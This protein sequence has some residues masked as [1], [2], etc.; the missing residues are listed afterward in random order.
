MAYPDEPDWSPKVLGPFSPVSRLERRS[1][2]TNNGDTPLWAATNLLRYRGKFF[3][4]GCRGF[5]ESIELYL[6]NGDVVPRNCTIYLMPHPEMGPIFEVIHA[7]PAGYGPAWYTVAISMMWN[8]DSMFIYVHGV[9]NT[10]WTIGYDLGTPWDGYEDN[11]FYDAS[12]EDRRYWMRA[13]FIGE[14]AGDVP[15]SGTINIIEIPSISA[16]RQVQSLN[17]PA[18]NDLYDTEQRGAGELLI[19][20][21]RAVSD[22]S[23]DYLVPRIRCDGNQVMPVDA[24][25]I[26]WYNQWI[27]ANA[28]GICIS[29]WDT[30]TPEY[31]MCVEIHYPFRNRLEVGFRNTDLANPHTGYVAYSYK[32]LS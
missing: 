7:I 10:W 32:R 21:F 5:L 13:N 15:V 20:Y 23:R 28:L 16:A 24:Q 31:T 1:T 14:T 17:V 22:A 29:K 3:P 27:H 2:L 11:T 30:T 8:Y 19:A 18:N 9:D 6:H 26:N 12:R 4:R 25:I